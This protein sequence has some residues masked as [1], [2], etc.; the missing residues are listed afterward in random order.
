MKDRKKNVRKRPLQGEN[1]P[2][3][4]TNTVSNQSRA[5]GS[6]AQ[7]V[8]LV[9]VDSQ[10]I[11]NLGPSKAS[12]KRNVNMGVNRSNTRGDSTTMKPSRQRKKPGNSLFYNPCIF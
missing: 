1:C 11:Q 3:A 2:P 5:L 8:K 9:L 10:N 6:D 12:L 7:T 4:A